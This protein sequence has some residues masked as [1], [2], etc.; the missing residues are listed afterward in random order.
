METQRE[1]QPK[2]KSVG[3][4]HMKII[5]N[6]DTIGETTTFNQFKWQLLDTYFSDNPSYL[7][8][9]HLDSFND[10]IQTGITQIF[11]ENNP[12]RVANKY[13][14]QEEITQ[15]CSIYIGGQNGNK[16]YFGKPVL[17]KENEI[18]NNEEKPKLM[19]PNHARLN[20]LTYGFTI[21][22]DVDIFITNIKDDTQELVQIEKCYF[23][24]F[25]LMLHS[26]LCILQGLSQEVRYNMGECRHDYG[27]YFIIDGKEKV[28]VSQ[29]KFGDNILYVKKNNIDDEF[30]YSCEIHSVSEDSSK[31]VRYT[32][33]KIV[34]SNIKKNGSKPEYSN[35]Q[36]VVDVPNVRRPIPLFILMRALGVQSDKEIIQYC[37]LDLENNNEMLSLFIPSVHDAGLI[38]T[39][40]LALQYIA[41]LTKKLTIIN[42]HNLLQNFFLP[43]IGEHNYINKAY[44]IGFMVNKLLRVFTGREKPTDRDNFKYKRVHNSGSLLYELFREYYL[45]EKK[46]IELTIQRYFFYTSSKFNKSYFE[47]ESYKIFSKE[48]LTEKGIMRGFKGSWG[49][50]SKTE[51]EGIVQDLNR[52]SWFSHISHLRRIVLPIGAQAKVTDPH[53][54]HGSQWGVID[55][56]DSPDGGNIG[57]HKHLAITSTIT[58][59]FSGNAFTAWLKKHFIIKTLL[60]CNP[61]DLA[62]S[63]KIFVNG[64][65]IGV[66][67][68]DPLKLM[69]DIK[70]CRKNGL[71]PAYL[72][73]SF[74]YQQN[75]FYFYT[76]AGRLIRP[77]FY[78]YKDGNNDMHISYKKWLLKLNQTSS[79]S[80]AANFDE[81]TL[82]WSQAIT[83]FNTTTEKNYTMRDNK[84]YSFDYNQIKDLKYNS[85]IIEFIDTSE[86][87]HSL[88]AN[89]HTEIEDYNNNNKSIKPKFTH[90]EIDNSLMF[91]VMGNSI[92]FP[93]NNQLPRNVFSCGQSKQ[94]VSVYHSNHT[95]RMDK[96]G[97]YLNYGQTPL[98][99]SNY[100]KY[101]NNESMPYGVNAIVAIM[102]YTGYNV[103]DAILIN[104]GS[105]KRGLFKTTYY[106]MY[107]STE[108]ESN[109]L[110]H[111]SALRFV[112]NELDKNIRVF[113]KEGYDYS[114]INEY[115]IIQENSVVHDK[116]ILIRQVSEYEDEKRNKIYKDQSITPKKGQLGFVDKIYMSDNKPGKRVAKVRIREDR[117]PMIGDKMASRAGQKGTIGII[118]PEEDMPFTKN[119]MRPDLII[120]PHAI[121]SRMTIGQLVE[122]QLNKLCCHYGFHGDCTAFQTQG[123]QYSIYGSML[124]NENIHHSGTELMYNGFTGE[125]IEADIFIGPTYYMRLKHMTKDKINFRTTGKRNY[126]TRQTNQGRANDG[127]LRIGEMERDAIMA[128]GLSYFLNESFLVRGDEYFMA[129]CNHSGAIA[130]YNKSK[131]IF[132]SPMADGPLQFSNIDEN[133]ITKGKVYV[134]PMS[135]FGRSFSIVRVPYSMKLLMQE[136]QTMNVQMRII[137]EDNVDQILNLSNQSQ[138]FQKLSKKI[139]QIHSNVQQEEQLDNFEELEKQKENEIFD[140]NDLESLYENLENIDSQNTLLNQ[141][142]SMYVEHENP[143]K[144]TAIQFINN[145][146]QGIID[147]FAAETEKQSLFNQKF[148]IQN[149][150]INLNQMSDKNDEI[151]VNLENFSKNLANKRLLNL[152]IQGIGNKLRGLLKTLILKQKEQEYNKM[153]K[154]IFLRTAEIKHKDL[155]TVK[156][157]KGKTDFL[158]KII[159]SLTTY[160]EEE[161]NLLIQF[162]NNKL[163][164]IIRND[165]IFLGYPFTQQIIIKFLT[166]LENYITTNPKI[167]VKPDII[168]ELINNN[169]T[170]NPENKK[171]LTNILNNL[172]KKEAPAPLPLMG[173]GEKNEIQINETIENEFDSYE[174]LFEDP[175]LN[176]L[177]ERLSEK[178]KEQILELDREQQYLVMNEILKR[179]P[180]QSQDEGNKLLKNAFTALPL[181]KQFEALKGGY[182]SMAKEFNTLSRTTPD[183]FVKINKPKLMS[184]EIAEKFPMLAVEKEKE[185]EKDNNEEEKK[186]IEEDETDGTLTIKKLK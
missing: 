22:F 67:D 133:E 57:Y 107:E 55:P 28:I 1:R 150:L 118:I 24:T 100:L 6:L 179:I 3:I 43:H 186:E 180:I 112:D 145:K 26:K 59:G 37:L 120:N 126:L 122:S 48:R 51:K 74:D 94:A 93:E 105:I 62:Y 140:A 53:K 142:F 30:S 109:D 137:T 25:P 152:Q 175:V 151:Y 21:H 85:G 168:E 45:V 80:A 121:P 75:T 81:H 119:G 7:V 113:I 77:I 148:V 165:N 13:K 185:Q 5:P 162:V 35:N 174:Q 68:N 42:V 84:F 102:S 56:V 33:V 49:S 2:K 60:R 79:S 154:E 159:Q 164:N 65:W 183:P 96:T 78:T 130:I 34:S 146:M 108:E 86:A 170:T 17:F 9:H 40:E 173:G 52:L 87:E 27:G 70:L 134:I 138:Y 155:R 147:K 97:I 66:Y 161:Q 90:C 104:E 12:I 111:E 36:I 171:L 141:I 101:I 125:T 16:I 64:N 177:F 61:F 11:K 10:F 31:P 124:T 92:I 144:N 106:S 98:V 18:P 29:E 135:K 123:S 32:S 131:K 41:M 44:F 47:N 158:D 129:I 166:S 73:I 128:N 71:I 178:T 163:E 157:F 156:V 8:A 19:Y 114:N 95:V 88:I 184:E 89:F 127:G 153:V 139:L 4:S 83:G 172:N 176:D 14:T 39:Q 116:S 50:Q 182:Q 54:L 63:T 99:K 149:V 46:N 160:S 76:D 136:L 82:T 15:H 181:D 117:I 38:F 132:L 58:N 167:Y 23:G 72:S 20:N 91:G 115:G 69:H 110:E 143:N 103:E 169:T